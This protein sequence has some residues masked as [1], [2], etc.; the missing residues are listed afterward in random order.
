MGSYLSGGDDQHFEPQGFDIGTPP[1]LTESLNT[2]DASWSDLQSSAGKITNPRRMG[3]VAFG[4]DKLDL[5]GGYSNFNPNPGTSSNSMYSEVLATSIPPLELHSIDPRMTLCDQPLRQ[6]MRLPGHVSRLLSMHAG[7]EAAS[8]P[9]SQVICPNDFDLALRETETTPGDTELSLAA[10]GWLGLWI[11]QHAERFPSAKELKC[12]EILSGVPG[13]S[14][15]SWLK[16]HVSLPIERHGNSLQQIDDTRQYRPKCLSSRPRRIQSRETRLFECTN[17]CGQTFSRHRKGDWAR[18]ERI[19]FEEW[20]CHVCSEALSRKEHLRVHLKDSHQIHGISLDSRRCQL[21]NSTERP[22]GFCHKRFPTWLAWLAHVAAH[23]EGTIGGR[24]WKMSEWKERKTSASGLQRQPELPSGYQKNLYDDG[25]DDG[26]VF[27]GGGGGGGDA[28]G[29]GDA[30]GHGYQLL[31]DADDLPPDNTAE[32]SRYAS[33]SRYR[34][35]TTLQTY[36]ES[37][38]APA[39][40]PIDEMPTPIDHTHDIVHRMATLEVSDAS[41]ESLSHVCAKATDYSCSCTDCERKLR[42][43]PLAVDSCPRALSAPSHQVQQ[44]NETLGIRVSWIYQ[45]PDRQYA[46]SRWLRERPVE[47]P[48]NSVARSRRS[49]TGKI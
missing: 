18:H 20:V 41:T 17:R 38:E 25:E 1:D 12:L 14:L 45:K 11:S 13:K 32:Y 34:G 48:W 15:M 9:P 6:E 19:N 43:E 40:R 47:E 31:R 5:I 35:S 10:L 30:S 28:S 46:V 37:K 7:A 23:F 22:C 8:G 16:K 26:N 44:N 29:W 39:L 2:L 21:L 33:S 42:L 27:G 36:G 3:D 24:K 4:T 49:G